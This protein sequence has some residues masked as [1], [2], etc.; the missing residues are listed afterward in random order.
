M[1]AVSNIEQSKRLMSL[2]GSDRTADFWRTPTVGGYVVSTE[3]KSNSTPA[4]SVAALSDMLYEYDDEE[5]GSAIPFINTTEE[6]VYFEA[7]GFL[8]RDFADSSDVI[9]NLIDAIQWLKENE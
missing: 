5:Y 7:N 6:T 8:V 9:D 4:W 3:K 1:Q 2:L